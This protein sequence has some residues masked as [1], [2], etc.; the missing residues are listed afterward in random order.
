M[1]ST[2]FD[3]ITSLERPARD[4]A[5][6][7]GHASRSGI[8]SD[9]IRVRKEALFTIAILLPKLLARSG[10]L[11]DDP[12]P[13]AYSRPVATWWF[14]AP[15]ADCVVSRASRRLPAAGSL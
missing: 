9:A 6:D 13:G 4:L 12:A 14:K 1:S 8:L 3:A 15:N 10:C 5:E 7:V 11:S 2:V